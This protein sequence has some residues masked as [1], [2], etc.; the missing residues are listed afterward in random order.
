MKNLHSKLQ[1]QKDGIGGNESDGNVFPVSSSDNLYDVRGS[2]PVVKM[3]PAGPEAA[4]AQV[5]KSP[6][7]QPVKAKQLNKMTLDGLNNLRYEDIAGG[8]VDGFDPRDVLDEDDSGD[9]EIL[10][11]YRDEEDARNQL[12]AS[13]IQPTNAPPKGKNHKNMRS[14]QQYEKE[15]PLENPKTIKMNRKAAHH[16]SI[17]NVNIT[18]QPRTNRRNELPMKSH[19][20]SNKNL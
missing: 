18:V 20:V 8:G 1:R 2:H 15:T 4:Y 3:Q 6:F 7:Q 19:Q 9:D 12:L 10:N 14:L 13:Q 16:N 17:S 5:D 11:R